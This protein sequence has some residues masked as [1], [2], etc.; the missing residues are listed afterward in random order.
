MQEAVLR[1]GAEACVQL[2]DKVQCLSRTATYDERPVRVQALETHMSWVFLTDRYAYKMKKPVQ[3]PQLDFSTLPLRKQNCL[4]ELRLNRRLARQVY[5]AVVPLTRDTHN[6]LVLDGTGQVVE[7]LVKMRRLPSRLMLDRALKS[8]RV[9]KD[10]IRRCI[11]LLGRFHTRAAPAVT[12]ASVY[13]A[14]LVESVEYESR[15][16]A[17]A[18]FGVAP[19]RLAAVTDPLRRFLESRKALFAD[20]VAAGRVIEGHGDLRPEH[21]CLSH[22]PV[23]IDCL[24]FNRGLRTLD[25]ADEV[26]YLAMECDCLGATEVAQS[27]IREHT[28]W[29]GAVPGSLLH[30]HQA[31]RA[32]VRARLSFWHLFDMADQRARWLARG[33][34]YMELAGEYA[35]QLND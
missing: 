21:V 2:E 33:N 27:I 7:W 19:A 6:R 13:W 31:R 24:E 10:D 25:V 22:P 30:F 29:V 3:L 8:G 5:L 28:R 9:S 26:G 32:L 23:I 16:L 1:N 34:R 14:G 20:R 35:S 12:D 15:A 4:E 11:S 17:S 18:E